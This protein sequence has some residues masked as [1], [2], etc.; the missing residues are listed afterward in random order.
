MLTDIQIRQAKGNGKAQRLWDERGLYLEVTPPGGK[1]W[2]FKYRMNGKEK[3]IG[4]GRYPDV[5]LALARE[6]RE[7]ARKLLAAGVD[8]S[9][10]RQAQKAATEAI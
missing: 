1:V 8:P 5:P 2:R 7:E 10:Q 6:R 9:V 4:F 3:R